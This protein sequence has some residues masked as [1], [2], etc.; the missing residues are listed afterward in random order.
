MLGGII[1][2]KEVELLMVVVI[3]C[4]FYK[5]LLIL[6]VFCDVYSFYLCGLCD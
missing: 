1:C 6:V 4:I 3:L 5:I 2:G